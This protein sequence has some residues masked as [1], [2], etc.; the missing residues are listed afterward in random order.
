MVA[1]PAVEPAASE[2]AGMVMVALPA[3]RTVA[4]DVYDPL[5][6]VTEPV[7]VG[8]VPLTLTV[9]ESESVVAMLDFAGVTVTVGVVGLPPPPPPP[10]P[11]LPPPQAASKTT[12]PDTRHNAAL[13]D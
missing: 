10:S 7:G 12:T 1:E 8:E 13:R 11:P 5:V 4:C 9:T 6:R 3:L 2:P